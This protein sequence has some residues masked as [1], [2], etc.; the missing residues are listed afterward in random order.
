M[1]AF[2]SSPPIMGGVFRAFESVGNI[3]FMA[4]A[5]EVEASPAITRIRV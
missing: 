4:G 2:L 3:V 1:L 5:S